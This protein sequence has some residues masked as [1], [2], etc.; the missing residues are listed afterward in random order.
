[1]NGRLVRPD[2]S[3]LSLF[4]LVGEPEVL[5]GVALENNGKQLV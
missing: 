1:M 2:H 4:P 3:E 5:Q